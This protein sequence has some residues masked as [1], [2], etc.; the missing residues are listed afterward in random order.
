MTNRSK[1]LFANY[2]RAGFFCEMFGGSAEPAAHTDA[3]RDRMRN[4]KVSTLQRRAQLSDRELYNLGITFTVYSDRNAIDRVLPFDVIPRV[5][6]RDDWSHIERGCVQR[7]AAL[8]RF[9]HDV[10]HEQHILNDGTVPAELVV[11]NR[12]LMMRAFPDLT[13]NVGLRRVSDYGMH[14]RAALAE[15][16][17]PSA[18]EPNV[19]LMLP[20]VFNSAYFEHVFLAREMGVPLVEGR[21]LVVEDDCV[22][23]KTTGGLRSKASRS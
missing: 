14:L 19:A 15:V 7:V 12:H 10:Y 16:A 6:S 8:N 21:D 20:G 13:G 1:G 18:A 2:D 4:M 11:E 22:F 5:L 3:I 23:M 17:P 9:L